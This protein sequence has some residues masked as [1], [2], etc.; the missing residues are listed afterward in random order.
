M[1][2]YHSKYWVSFLLYL[3]IYGGAYVASATAL[4]SLNSLS[5]NIYFN[6]TL[7]NFLETIVVS[8]GSFIGH[9]F[10]V[11]K[12]LMIA[13]S[14]MTIGYLAEP[15][16][17][18]V[19]RYYVIMQGKLF[20]DTLWAMMNIFLYDIVPKRFIPIILTTKNL[21]CVLSMSLIPYVKY[22]MEAI[23]LTIFL[24]TGIYL[25]VSVLFLR[26]IKI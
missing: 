10:N 22:G 19:L 25:G 16:L 1:D 20:T 6:I 11:H 8:L 24:F 3:Y 9:F 14:I 7:V 5:G 17:P 21:S 23:G 18:T 2:L 4:L 12:V 13:L 26:I 15:F